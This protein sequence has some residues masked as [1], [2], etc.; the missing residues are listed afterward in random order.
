MYV[1]SDDTGICS[2]IHVSGLG[3]NVGVLV[4]FLRETAHLNNTNATHQLS[5]ALQ[6]AMHTNNMGNSPKLLCIELNR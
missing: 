4:V 3:Y 6:I 5:D 2:Y 1:D